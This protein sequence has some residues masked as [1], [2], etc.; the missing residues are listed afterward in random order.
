MQSSPPSPVPIGVIAGLTLLGS[1][2]FASPHPAA[3]TGSMADTS[4]FASS[5]TPVPGIEGVPLAF[6]DFDGDSALDLLT[7]TSLMPGR[8]DGTFRPALPLPVTLSASPPPQIAD[9]NGDGRPDIVSPDGSVLLSRGDG[10]F[11]VSATL[12]AAG[13]CAVADLIEDGRPDVAVLAGTR[14]DIFPNIGNGKFGPPHVLSLYDLLPGA[15]PAVTLAAGDVTCDGHADLIV[16]KG[17][18][19]SVLPGS[20]DGTFLPARPATFAADLRPAPPLAACRAQAGEARP[21]ARPY[22]IE[23]GGTDRIV[24]ADVDGDGCLDYAAN[25]GQDNPCRPGYVALSPGRAGSF[26]PV[27]VYQGLAAGPFTF[28]DLEG[29]GRK[30]L[31]CLS[32]DRLTVTRW[33]GARWSTALFGCA[34]T[35]LVV[36]DVDGDGR[37]DLLIDHSLWLGRAA[38]TLGDYLAVH[39]S[40]A[41]S[42]S[43]DLNGD[44]LSDLVVAETASDSVL[45]I[46]S[47]AGRRWQAPHAYAAG[48]VPAGMKLADL[49]GDGRP[50]LVAA[51]PE[52]GSVAILPGLRNGALGDAKLFA[53]GLAAR[54]IAVGDVNGDGRPDVVAVSPDQP[55]ISILYGDGTGGF[56]RPVTIPALSAGADVAVGDIDGDGR[57]EIV[58]AGDSTA[59]LRHAGADSLGVERLA[60]PATRRVALADFD[61]DGRLDVLL[62]RFQDP[63]DPV[64]PAVL[65]LVLNSGD[66]GFAP[67]IG[68]WT[69]ST[70]GGAD[71]GADEL[72]VGDVDGDGAADVVM[73]R[74]QGG[75]CGCD[76]VGWTDLVFGDGHGGARAAKHDDAPFQPRGVV[77]ADFDGDGAVDVALSDSYDR[78][79]GGDAGTI[80]TLWNEAGGAAALGLTAFAARR[81]GSTVELHWRLGPASALVAVDLER[82]DRPTG[83]WDPMLSVPGGGAAA[84]DVTDRAIAPDRT[85]YYRLVVTTTDGGLRTFGPIRETADDSQPVLFALA[86]GP[87][88]AR[89]PVRIDFALPREADARV[90]LFDVAGREIARLADG[91]YQAG[92]HPLVWTG[93]IEG[94]RSPAGLYFVRLGSGGSVVVQRVVITR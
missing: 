87:N 81:S 18:A 17:G 55:A 58:V 70:Y 32:A 42:A 83:R 91:R 79:Q 75:C 50:D 92:R 77:I 26:D 25:L 89:G 45:V 5:I 15:P 61:R 23:V 52:S 88:P 29:D 22:G 49:N 1:I 2:A 48:G 86:V 6:A 21:S 39:G 7:T 20:G 78:W 54:R 63:T 13:P 46:L 43:A 40:P 8:G 62:Y 16:G 76:P 35:T 65:D 14:I 93:E 41:A 85:Y 19:Y 38:R 51:L 27:T 24:L 33:D 4:V 11:R 73:I 57:A 53:A 59:I 31:V 34:A 47:G 30:E 82:G 69:G 12:S 60:D 37:D 74:A 80:R 90:S 71:E 36:G 9:L 28:A 94:R 66:G 67:P 68:L 44:G 64:G 56:A 84:G 72:A 10:T 3:R